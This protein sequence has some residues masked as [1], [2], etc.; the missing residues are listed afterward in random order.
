MSTYEA[1]LTF[2]LELTKVADAEII[3]RFRKTATQYKADGSEV[4]EAD[5]EAELAM[6]AAITS[7]YPK[8]AILG[9]EF[10]DTGPADARYRWVLDP[11]DGTVLFTL[12]VP[13]FGTLIG[14]L[15]DGVPV[16]GIIHF[17]ALDE[18]MYAYTGGGCWLR[19]RNEAARRVQVD[20]V[21]GLDRAFLSTTGF[22]ATEIEP[23]AG[24]TT[25]H[26]TSLIQQ[27]GRFR[28][29]GDCLQH[30]LVAQGRLHSAIDT[31]MKPWDI[32]AI[33]PCIAEAGGVA[34]AADGNQENI[35]FSG[36]LVTSCSPSLH[37][38]VIDRLNQKANVPE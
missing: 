20:S 8:H 32:A 6:R 9:E 3:P 27:A 16:M 37:Q 31:I 34:S 26:I 5:R 7:R 2:A 21:D 13:T 18:T 4:T 23:Q 38:V 15:E 1:Y 29:C 17:P 12:G 25:Y 22:H 24:F 33:L 19:T 35:V 10:P 14:L 30:S 28:V 11:V 36:S